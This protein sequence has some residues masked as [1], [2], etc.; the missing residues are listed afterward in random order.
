MQKKFSIDK[1]FVSY[2]L[3]AALSF[4]S[5]QNLFHSNSSNC[6]KQAKLHSSRKLTWTSAK[7]NTKISCS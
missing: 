5:I 2:F 3:K 1:I 4:Y 6:L 7:F